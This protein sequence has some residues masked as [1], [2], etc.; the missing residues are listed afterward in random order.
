MLGYLILTL[1]IA[2]NL[3]VISYYFVTQREDVLSLKN[4]LTDMK[5]DVSMALQKVDTLNEKYTNFLGS[6]WDMKRSQ[7]LVLNTPIR[8]EVLSSQQNL[9]SPKVQVAKKPVS[10]KAK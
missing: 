4:A 8:V 5:T 7:E 10:D 9:Q 1:G 2:M 6:M 3:L